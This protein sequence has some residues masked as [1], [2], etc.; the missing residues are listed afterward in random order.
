MKYKTVF[1]LL[2]AVVG[3]SLVYPQSWK[4]KPVAGFKAFNGSPKPCDNTLGFTDTSKIVTPCNMTTDSCDS[5]ID[6]NWDFGDGRK[7]KLKSP[8]TKYTQNGY[9][10]ITLKITTKYGYIDSVN[11]TIYIGGPQPQ[12]KVLTDTIFAGDSAKFANWSLDPL[13]RPVWVWNFGDGRTTYDTVYRDMEH[14]Y[15]KPGIYEVYLTQFDNINGTKIRCSAIYPDTVAVVRKK[16]T[17]TVLKSSKVQNYSRSRLSIFPNPIYDHIFIKGLT[18]GELIIFDLSG[19]EV[20][21]TD[22]NYNESVDIS[23]LNKGTYFIRCSEGSS[24]YNG[25]FVKV[26]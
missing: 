14:G 6:W 5:I 17:V 1:L 15:T 13:F 16:I 18:R 23:M 19:K 21:R 22:I 11:Y 25:R 7:S 3:T 2:I 20:L 26:M 12:F 24:S 9:F 4:P 8:I 10:T